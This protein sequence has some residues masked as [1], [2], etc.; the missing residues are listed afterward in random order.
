MVKQKEGTE[1]H[2]AQARLSRVIMN[3][4][5]INR[6]WRI[7]PRWD[8][9]AQS[10]AQEEKRRRRDELQL[11]STSVLW[12]ETVTLTPSCKGTWAVMRR[13][14]ELAKKDQIN[15]SATANWVSERNNDLYWPGLGKT[16]HRSTGEPHV[17]IGVPTTWEMHYGYSVAAHLDTDLLECKECSPV[18]FTTKW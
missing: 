1:R 9:H 3:A 17:E 13:E 12:S 5:K 8:D 18:Y 7:H 14:G 11:L 6:G 2:D 15:H 4:S 16:I 10:A